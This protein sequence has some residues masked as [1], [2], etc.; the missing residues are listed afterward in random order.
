MTADERLKSVLRELLTAMREV[1]SDE[2]AE[3]RRLWHDL[4]FEKMER[5]RRKFEARR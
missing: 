3:E 5:V 4:Q 1:S 2:D